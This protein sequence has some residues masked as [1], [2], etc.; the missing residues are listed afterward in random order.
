MPAAALAPGA[1]APMQSVSPEQ[2]LAAQSAYHEGLAHARENRWLQAAD[3]YEAA[4]AAAAHDPVLWL[5]LAHARLKLGDT[6]RSAT[7][8]CRAV[9]LDPRSELG[10]T[11][12]AQC[13]AHAG[14]QQDL[15]ALF[16]SVDMHAIG[17][18][19]L[20]LQLGLAL[21][22]LE[23]FEEAIRAF[24]DVL[25]RNPRS[26]EAF[27]Q[28]GNVFQLMQLPEQARE[29]FRNALAL[30]RTPV[31]MLSAVLF[32][33]LEA[34]RWESFEEDRASL[35]A[36]AAS[37]QGQPVPFYCLAFS[38]T[39]SQQ[40]AAARAYAQ[41]TFRGI[42]TA[43]HGTAHAAARPIRVGYVS[44]DLHE[45]ATA[46]LISELLERHDRERFEIYAYSYGNNDA[47]PMR[48]RIETA[49]GRTFVDAR[50]MST[51]ALVQRISQDAIDVLIDLK[52]YTLYARNDV[53]A[54]RPAPIQVNFLGF[55]GTLG[56]E[57]YDYIIGDPIV[58]PLEHADGFAEKIAQLPDCY[59]PNDRL[60]PMGAAPDRERWQ[61]PRNGFVF[62]CFNAAYKITPPVFDRWCSLL[63]QIDDS[64]LWLLET[65]AQARK[66]IL[67]QAQ[68]RGIAPDR[69]IWAPRVGFAQHI[70]R[71]P[72]ADVFLDTLPVNAHTT[73]S[74][75]LWAG[76][77]VLTVL[78]ESFVSRVAAS[79]VTAAQ[80]PE[81]VA[82]D[83]DE[84]ERIALRLARDRTWLRDLRQRLADNRDRCALFDSAAYQRN[85]EALLGR[86]VARRNRGLA[87]EHLPAAARRI[88]RA[89]WPGRGPA[90]QQT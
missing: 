45:H 17:D 31:E 28:L 54:H 78:G 51:P 48:R 68:R 35:E 66:N 25:V 13:F 89:P 65:N 29:S 5:N 64:V 38:W 79:A 86:M 63:R 18:A 49:V 83:L 30:G 33:S 34:A 41:R 4:L 56:S 9:A 23:R 53:F 52:G 76:L 10:L 67:L 44:S 85:F 40:L 19:R 72:T 32:T 59:Q 58:T 82:A 50:Q 90:A 47:S 42:A 11:I 57:H 69:L 43:T 74:D 61:L 55:P 46:Y 6:E 81:L 14:R 21:C 73:A 20:H 84:Y 62:C 75:A 26:A 7:A 27:A 24:L 77:P 16:R 87:P 8:A 88:E 1:S 80:L 22:R 36:L 60:R 3:A 37:G 70:A 2:Q 12:A 39:R 15:V 71:L